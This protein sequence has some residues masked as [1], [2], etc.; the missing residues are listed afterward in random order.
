MVI[1][2]MWSNLLQANGEKKI[3]MVI[4][5]YGQQQGEEKPGYE[6]DEFSQAYLI[7]KQNNI[8]IDIASP[9]GGAV[10]ADKF[11]KTKSFNK[12]V[13]ADTVVMTKLKNTLAMKDIDASVYDGVFVVGGKGAMFDLP[14]DTYLHQVI[15]DIYQN[16]GSVAAV[17]HGP[18]ALTEVK[19]SNGKYLVDGKKVNGFTNKEELMFGKKWVKHFDF[20]LEDKLKERG[21]NFQSSDVMLSHVAIDGRLLTGQNPASTPKIA[22]ALVASIGLNPV[23]RVKF[24]EELSLDFIADIWEGNNDNASTFDSEKYDA[25][26]LAMYGY[27]RMMYAKTEDENRKAVTLLEIA[28]P[29]FEH[30]N[31]TLSLAK[32]Y[33]QLAQNEKAKKLLTALISKHPEMKEAKQLLAKL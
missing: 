17:C 26:L 20:M 18:A 2:V 31:V 14:K 7:F 23:Q 12:Q 24:K 10:E 27:Y 22:Q 28:R 30:P 25:K 5:G 11:N 16:N 1:I 8:Q 4:S 19:L 15:A 6:F 3:L 9:K 13:L 32:G 33:H 21:G 29:H